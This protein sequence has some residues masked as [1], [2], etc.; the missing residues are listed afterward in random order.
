MV[1]GGHRP[2]EER[3]GPFPRFT[4]ACHAQGPRSRLPLVCRTRT[5]RPPPSWPC[6]AAALTCSA[7]SSLPARTR[8][9]RSE[10]PPEVPCGT[11]ERKSPPTPPRA[12]MSTGETL[13]FRAAAENDGKAVRCLFKHGADPGKPSTWTPVRHHCHSQLALPRPG[14]QMG[15]RIRP[16]T[17]AAAIS[18]RRNQARRPLG[19]GG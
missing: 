13:L 16:S 8:T 9:G 6:R 18:R 11:T 2:V 10:A 15:L 19:T 3:Y 14:V 7:T 4:L 17:A 1:Q 5:A 12:Q